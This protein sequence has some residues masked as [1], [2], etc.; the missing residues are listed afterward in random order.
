MDDEDLDAM[1]LFVLSWPGIVQK[2]S[3]GVWSRC[4]DGRLH[5]H[6]G[7]GCSRVLSS[8]SICDSDDT[9]SSEMI[10]ISSL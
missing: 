6:I 7:L 2:H 9:L 1:I 4:G 10:L 8:Q 3:A 5:E